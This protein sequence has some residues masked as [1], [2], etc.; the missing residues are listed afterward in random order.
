MLER[1]DEFRNSIHGELADGILLTP[2]SVKDTELLGGLK[3][4]FAEGVLNKTILP[5][6]PRINGKTVSIEEWVNYLS[7]SESSLV[8]SIRVQFK[9]WEP[10]HT[11]GHV[12]AQR[13]IGQPASGSLDEV[14]ETRIYIHRMTDRGNAV[15][16]YALRLHIKSLKEFGLRNLC[17]FVW[18]YNDPS[19]AIHSRIYGKPRTIVKGFDPNIRVFET[20]SDFLGM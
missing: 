5:G 2:P 18:S 13:L 1:I 8:H 19:V 10:Y 14:Y 11:V 17:A 6:S 12:T 3:V 16:E 7:S 20:N 9:S 15:G 4:M